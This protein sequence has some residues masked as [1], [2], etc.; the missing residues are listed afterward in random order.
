MAGTFTI[1]SKVEKTTVVGTDQG[2]LQET[3]AGSVKKFLFSTLAD[4]V[5]TRISDQAEKTALEATDILVLED[6][7]GAVKKTLLSSLMVFVHGL[8]HPVGSFYVQYPDAADNDDAVAFPSTTRPSAMF[9]GTWAEQFNTENVFFRT[10]GTNYQ[11]RTAGMSL[12]EIE[13]HYHASY[14]TAQIVGDGGTGRGY[15]IQNNFGGNT[16]LLAADNVRGV[17]TD[18]TNSL[19]AGAVTEPRNRLMKV[20][21][22][23]S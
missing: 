13:S 17:T 6:S 18:G 1:D 22:R 2:L 16:T 14:G 8:S 7:T 21:K 20:W 4:Y 11:T 12:D 19:R 23:L 10:A 3:A 5:F 9:G 15:A